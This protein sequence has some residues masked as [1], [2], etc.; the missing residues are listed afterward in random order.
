MDTTTQP[1]STEDQVDATLASIVKDITVPENIVELAQMVGVMRNEAI[2]QS[3]KGEEEDRK[4]I[5]FRVILFFQTTAKR[6]GGV[7]KRHWRWMAETAFAA[8]I[9]FGIGL[10]L[11]ILVTYLF[12]INPLLAWGFITAMVA[13]AVVALSAFAAKTF[14]R[15]RNLTPVEVAVL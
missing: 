3:E 13:Q 10:G 11:R 9:G 2:S 7:F 14:L 8:I 12:T 6:V 15:R 4:S 5:A 1:P